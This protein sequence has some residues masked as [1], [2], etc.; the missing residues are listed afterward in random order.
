MSVPD[1][2]KGIAAATAASF[3]PRLRFEN[4]ILVLSHMRSVSTALTHVLAT[5]P[6][7]WGYG[8]THV[9]Y[10]AERAPGRLWLNLL[11]HQRSGIGR[12]LI[13]DKVLHNDLDRAVMPAFYRARAVFLLRSPAPAIR[14]IQALSVAQGLADWQS[15]EQ[16]ARYYLMRITRLMH[17]WNHFPPERRIGM[18]SE[19]LM[20]DPEGGL[21]RLSQFLPV[22]HPLKNRYV[23][24]GRAARH[25]AGDPTRSQNLTK[26]EPT[27]V[28]VDL[29]LPVGVDPKLAAQCVQ[30]YLTL[31]DLMGLAEH[32][33][34]VQG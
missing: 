8:E 10:S 3:L 9:S 6:E 28:D 16:A 29:S 27:D 2:I 21:V 17:H 13:L 22:S 33:L 7:I 11:R 15:P 32:A 12:K 5:H 20:R 1:H 25:G 4:S 26:I 18:L 34:T 24:E 14:S 31:L 19:N 23:A 30:A